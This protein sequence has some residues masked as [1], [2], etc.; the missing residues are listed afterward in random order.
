MR[1]EEPVNVPY[2]LPERRRSRRAA[3]IGAQSWLSVASTWPV[4]LLDLSMSG[5]AFSSPYGLD[6]GRTAVVRATLG[7]SPFNGQIRV[8]WSRPRGASSS[9]RPP[10]EIGAVF[11]PLEDGSRVALESFLKVSSHE[12]A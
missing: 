10:F 1:A 7:G 12:R 11:L 8:C 4:Q 3:T 2:G 5:M 6:V 9:N